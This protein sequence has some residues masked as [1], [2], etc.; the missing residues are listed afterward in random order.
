MPIPVG[1]HRQRIA[2][3]YTLLA[4]D[5]IGLATDEE[6]SIVLATVEYHH[7]PLGPQEANRP[8][9]AVPIHLVER[10]LRVDE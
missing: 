9:H 6:G 1:A 7:G 8:K 4:E 5:D 10:V 3:G 2:L